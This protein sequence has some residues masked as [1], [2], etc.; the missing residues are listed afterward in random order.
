[1]AP[2]VLHRIRIILADD[3]AEIRAL[4][5][6]MLAELGFTNVECAV[7]GYDAYR[8]FVMKPA[9]LVI[10]DLS[11]SPVDGLELIRLIRTAPDSPNRYVPII[12]LSCNTDEES[13]AQARDAGIND[14]LA[15]PMSLNTLYSHLE[16]LIARP[17]N[18]IKTG[19]YFG[20]NR[21][22]HIPAQRVHERR[23]MQA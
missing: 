10:T 21:R 3:Q 23:S 2:S 5:R 7:D 19:S 1:M 15:K 13:V 16:A 9:S 6:Q 18:F 4:G 22:R 17:Q 8:K 11:M 14:F 20:P 12:V